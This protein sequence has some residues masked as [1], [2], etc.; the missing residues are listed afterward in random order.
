[1][2]FLYLARG[3][4][5][6]SLF[7]AIAR[8]NRVYPCKDYGYIINYYGNFKNPDSDL[9]MYANDDHAFDDADWVST[10]KLISNSLDGLP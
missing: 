9:K 6:H 10:L 4:K 8:V 5:D 1:M 3:L 7:Q 2:K